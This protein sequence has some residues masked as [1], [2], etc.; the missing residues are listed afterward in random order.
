M[1]DGTLVLPER[2]S[3]PTGVSVSTGA[4]WVDE[5][6]MLDLTDSDGNSFVGVQLTSGSPATATSS[7][8][9]GQIAVSGSYLYVCTGSEVWQRG[10]LTTW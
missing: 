8:V 6:G 9:I 1:S 3:A 7:G 5:D 10:T 2:A 4:I